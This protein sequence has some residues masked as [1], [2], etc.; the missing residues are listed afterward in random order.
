MFGRAG[1]AG[2]GPERTAPS[3]C[4]GRRG[5]A[6]DAQSPGRGE[7]GDPPVRASA[8]R[9]RILMPHTVIGLPPAE[10]NLLICISHFSH[11]RS[12]LSSATERG[13]KACQTLLP[14]LGLL[15]TTFLMLGDL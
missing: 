1:C 2:P 14:P 3:S 8:E 6:G 13:E 15:Q 10:V 4:A 7:R 11:T 5:L 9:P 12:S